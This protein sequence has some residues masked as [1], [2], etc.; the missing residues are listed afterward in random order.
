[1][2]ILEHIIGRK[3]NSYSFMDQDNWQVANWHDARCILLGSMHTQSG[4][5]V[6]PNPEKS[7]NW[8]EPWDFEQV[9]ALFVSAG[10]H[11]VNTMEPMDT[12]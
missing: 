10:I 7:P 12:R 3:A 11:T 2:F 9:N 8:E 4:R 5:E 1:M 6:L